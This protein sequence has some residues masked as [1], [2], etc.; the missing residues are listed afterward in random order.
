M[1]L[2]AV[3][4]MLVPPLFFGGNW[5]QWIYEGLVILVIACPCALVISTPISIVAGLA[6]AA[7]SGVLIK[8]GQYL[9]IPSKLTAL[10]FD[11]TG[12]ITK[13]TPMI[14]RIIPIVGYHEDIVL[15]IASALEEKSSHPL[16]RAV[17][18]CARQ[19]PTMFRP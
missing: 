5:S 14:Q 19:M 1:I 16:A 9:E 8:G 3:L 13:G 17:L 7:R 12:T 10:A 11:K 15:Q 2:L 6:S 4:I 18:S